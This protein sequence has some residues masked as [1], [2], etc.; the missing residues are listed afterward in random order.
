MN[1]NLLTK[2]QWALIISI[3]LGLFLIQGLTAL[4]SSSNPKERL[5][6]SENHQIITASVDIEHL[7]TRDDLY[8]YY[9]TKGGE[10]L[11][12]SKAENVYFLSKVG[13]SSIK[14][15]S[16]LNL[17]LLSG[18][19]LW[20][21]ID[22]RPAPLGEP[23]ATGLET[24]SDLIFVSSLG[25]HQT[26]GEDIY[27]AAKITAF[28][29]SGEKI[30]SRRIGGARSIS[31]MV[32]SDE[33]VSVDGNF[34]SHYYGLE[35]YSGYVLE[36]LDKSNHNFIYFKDEGIRYERNGVY[37]IQ[38]VNI[39]TDQ[40]N[41]V[42]TFDKKTSLSPYLTDTAV[43]LRTDV[44]YFPGK[45]VA[46]QRDS[47]NT[48]WEYTDVLSNVAVSESV[49]Y[50]LTTDMKLLGVDVDTGV[51]FMEIDFSTDELSDSEIVNNVFQVA[52]NKF[53][54]IVYFGDRHQLSAY[55]YSFN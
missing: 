20:S 4:I 52:A 28:N 35:P 47:G 1:Q 2:K 12:E 7:W 22:N 55:R 45:A 51:I 41:W 54:L 33:F 18:E 34:S 49:A 9:S 6:S 23:L 53:F 42:S 19:T 40:V 24:N 26:S 21:Q 16:L 8:T 38:S 11:L 43:V 50:F 37:S 27:G 32:S 30:W 5:G 13:D 44:A 29:N 25:T 10:R 36:S 14:G 46:I 39:D 3:V 31:T 17:N 48:I 15:L